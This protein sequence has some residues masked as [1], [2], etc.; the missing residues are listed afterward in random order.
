LS[1]LAG[2]DEDPVTIQQTRDRLRK[3]SL[4]D[5]Y[6]HVCVEPF[7]A[8][9]I[10]V[11]LPSLRGSCTRG[12]TTDHSTRSTSNILKQYVE[13]VDDGL[14]QRWAKLEVL[15]DTEGTAALA[16]LVLHH[17]DPPESKNIRKVQS[18]LKPCVVLL[19]F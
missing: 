13:E 4:Y 2:T 5:N 3:T 11:R 8:L 14:K 17:T 16:Q 18:L 1:A 12:N 7:P 19:S 9:P 10:N 15:P 6:P